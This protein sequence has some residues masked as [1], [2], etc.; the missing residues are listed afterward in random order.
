MEDGAP[1]FPRGFSG[2]VVLGDTLG[3]AL[4]FAYGAVTR[5]GAPFQTASAIHCFCNSLGKPPFARKGPTTPTL[6]RRR[7]ITQNWFGLFP[8]RSP[9][10]G[11]SLLISFPEGT[12]MFQFPS[13]TAR[14]LCIQ[15]R[16]RW[17]APFGN[18]RIKACLRLPEAYR[19]L[20]RPS[21]PLGTKA[22]T[23]RP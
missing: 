15:P 6:Q 22:S 16:A 3:R 23:V 4:H 8:V 2:L 19:S 7:A 5:C 17:V 9:L 13:F 10:L 21:S 20:P 14:G 11:E 18:P 1:S 12:E